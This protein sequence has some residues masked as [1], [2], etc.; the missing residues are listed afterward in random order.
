MALAVGVLAAVPGIVAC[1]N[2]EDRGVRS[3]DAVGSSATPTPSTSTGPS[4]PSTEPTS[5]PEEG[6][7]EAM[8][9]RITINDHRFLA[10]LT[11]SVAARDLVAQLP[12]TIAMRDH[13]GVE[14][15]GRL[16]SAL[17]LDGQP[18]GADPAVGD[19]GYYAPGNDFVLYYGD[20]SYFSGIVVLG[21]LTDDA[22]DRIAAL[23]GSVTA[24]IDVAS[25]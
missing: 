13:G 12:A 24:T 23:H 10:T 20:Q 7:E 9:I 18:E 17:S 3:G 25:S 8:E 15:T 2:A 4:M 16:P 5:D 21:R 14:K 1:S 19:V 6:E 22:V 11:D